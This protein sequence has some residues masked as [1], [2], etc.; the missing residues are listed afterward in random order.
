[1]SAV[2]GCCA[3][4][5]LRQSQ[6]QGADGTELGRQIGGEHPFQPPVADVR[7]HLRPYELTDTIA[8]H[9]FILR[10]EGIDFVEVGDGRSQDE[11]S[12]PGSVNRPRIV[13]SARPLWT[14]A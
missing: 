6:A 4:V 10:V 8:Y 13:S 7:Q 5:L 14:C 12:S 2:G 3:T 1:V 9:A 11:H